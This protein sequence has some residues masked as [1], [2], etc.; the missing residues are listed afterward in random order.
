ML[1]QKDLGLHPTLAALYWVSYSISLSLWLSI[2]KI[3]INTYLVWFWEIKEMMV[4]K[5]LIYSIHSSFKAFNKYFCF[6]VIIRR[7]LEII[8]TYIL[9][10]YPKKN[11][12]TSW[13]LTIHRV[14]SLY[15]W[16]SLYACFPTLYFMA[17]ESYLELSHLFLLSP[18]EQSTGN[19]FPYL[20]YYFSA[21]F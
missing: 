4:T 19:T 7:T 1:D 18:H 10:N 16:I 12:V 15:V 8:K 14:P 21:P 6:S 11:T 17:M 5:S 9:Y 2:C 13:W 20:Y 3:N